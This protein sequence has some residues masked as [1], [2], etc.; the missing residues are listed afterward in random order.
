MPAG[1]LTVEDLLRVLEQAEPSS[2]FF[3]GAAA[4]LD[5]HLLPEPGRCLTPTP[6]GPRRLLTIGMATYNDYDGV[7]FS[8]EALRLYHPEITDDTEILVIDN[9]PQGPCAGALK[10][11]ENYVTGY[12]YYPYDSFHGTTVR[13]LLFREANS[14]YVLSMDSHVF[15]PQGSLSRFVDFLRQQHHTLDLWQGPLLSDG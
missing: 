4:V 15:F 3:Q 13:D 8:V 2:A 5:S 11:L 12:R 14:E 9:N 1:E 10:R 6:R 7:Y